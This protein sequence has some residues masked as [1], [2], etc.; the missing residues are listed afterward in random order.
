MSPNRR[1]VRGRNYKSI[2]F[3]LDLR[4]GPNT[5]SKLMKPR[6]TK[7]QNPFCSAYESIGVNDVPLKV[8]KTI[9]GY[10]ERKLCITSLVLL[11]CPW[12]N[13]VFR[14]ARRAL[15][16]PSRKHYLWEAAKCIHSSMHDSLSR[17]AA[18][19]AI[20]PALYKMLHNL[21]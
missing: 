5:R 13:P 4:S 9:C 15:I 1:K 2:G 17:H 8:R 11:T 21:C 6:G 18:V 3:V 7:F 12:R 14:M 10:S 20:C 19:T 16:F